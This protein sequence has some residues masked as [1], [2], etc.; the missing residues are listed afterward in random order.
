MKKILH[1]T[2]LFLS[3]QRNFIA[4]HCDIIDTIF[5]SAAHCLI[6]NNVNL[7]PGTFLVSLGRYRLRDWRG[8]GS[9]NREVEDYKLHPDYDGS[10]NADSDLAV[11]VLRESVPYTSVIKPICLWSGSSLLSNVVGK[12]GHVVGWG[13]DEAGNRYVQ[14]PRQTKSPIVAQE[15]CLWSNRNFVA[16]TSNR[17]FCAGERNGSGPCNGDSGS[18]FVIYNNETDRYYLRGVVS[19]SLL[20]IDIRVCIRSHSRGIEGE[21]EING[22]KNGRKQERACL[23]ILNADLLGT[24]VREKSETQEI[25]QK[26][27]KATLETNIP[28]RSI[29]NTLM[30]RM[31]EFEKLVQV[32]TVGLATMRQEFGNIQSAQSATGE[33]EMLTKRVDKKQVSPTQKTRNVSAIA[34]YLAEFTG[35]FDGYDSEYELVQYLIEGI[36]DPNLRNQARL[37]KFKTRAEISEAFEDVM[38]RGPTTSRGVR[39]SGNNVAVSSSRII[40]EENYE[41]NR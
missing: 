19:R 15:V 8:N 41:V 28:E 25:L 10:G 23:S 16:F 14:E 39:S 24:W 4:E 40:G 18:G 13:R 37:H 26:A 34:D 11:L 12:V 2:Q 20:D 38:L 31:D 1:C 6:L 9:V 7:P 36:S 35:E 21:V 5:L 17:T 33:I 30:K 32:I 29:D 27:S 3:N 22:P